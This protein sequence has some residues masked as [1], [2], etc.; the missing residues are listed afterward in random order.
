MV[1]HIRNI[2]YSPYS[3]FLLFLFVFWQLLH[4]AND[5]NILTREFFDGNLL[6][7]L[8]GFSLEGLL[9]VAL[10]AIYNH[11]KERERIKSVHLR[12]A[13]AVSIFPKGVSFQAKA[14][15]PCNMET[16]NGIYKKIEETEGI[17]YD[18]V[19]TTLYNLHGN[20]ANKKNEWER[21]YLKSIYIPIIQHAEFSK[22]RLDELQGL[23]S[24]IGLEYLDFFNLLRHTLE[25]IISLKED[26]DAQYIQRSTEAFLAVKQY[27]QIAEEFIQI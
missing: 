16:L 27:N 21:E 22:S 25:D 14:K 8:I 4:Y 26:F 2:V 13:D 9:F 3:V 24:T 7:E 1:R 17:S 11:I 10:L 15:R 23:A 12:L 5:E 20:I 19:T 6:P 18:A